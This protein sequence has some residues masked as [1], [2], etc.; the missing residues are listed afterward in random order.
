MKPG[1]KLILPL[2]IA[3]VLAIAGTHLRS[4]GG[5]SCQA[6]L[7]VFGSLFGCSGP[8]SDESAGQTGSVQSGA[9]SNGQ[10][11]AAQSRT[12]LKYTGPVKVTFIE[13]GSVNCIPCKMMQPVMRQIEESYP[14]QVKVVFYDVWTE[15]G[16]PY[17][18]KYG[19]R[20]IPTQIFL[21]AKGVEYFRHAGYFPFEEVDKILKMKGV[22]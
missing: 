16:Q 4:Q 5:C 1:V 2:A 6:P 21:N 14:G 7:I 9:E 22:E 12:P 18:M 8:A 19:I 15:Q 3:A 13:L 17:G 20:A 10:L 11:I